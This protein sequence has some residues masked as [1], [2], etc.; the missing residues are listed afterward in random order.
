MI[1]KVP[2][3]DEPELRQRVNVFQDRV[4]AGTHLARLLES[5]KTQHPVVLAIPAGGVPVAIE[6][7]RKLSLRMDVAV[8]SKIT[9]PNNTEVGYG[10][11]AFDGTVELNESL[12]LDF[13]LSEETVQQGIDRT[14]DKVTQRIKFL[15]PVVTSIPL[16][17]ENVLLV[18]DGLASGITMHAAV[19][20]VKKQG[21]Q[22][23]TVAVPTGHESSLMHLAQ[24]VRQVYCANVRSGWRFA[25]AE[26]YRH[27]DDLSDAD[28][29]KLLTSFL[30]SH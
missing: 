29:L 6:I 12:I 30:S 11:V 9:P 17:K 8:V 19:Q 22:H 23:V 28:I 16:Q 7:A 18:D 2:W 3:I 21:A 20:A 13:S 5:V 10:A 25:V 26:A 27:W 24:E 4:D 1:D 15:R 14:R